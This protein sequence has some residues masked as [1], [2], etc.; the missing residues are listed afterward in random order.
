MESCDKRPSF[1]ELVQRV[2]SLL[3]GVAGYIDFSAF[4]GDSQTVQGYDH[5][6]KNITGYMYDHLEKKAAEPSIC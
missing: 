5:L 4:C 2:N 1:Q 6:E 3:E